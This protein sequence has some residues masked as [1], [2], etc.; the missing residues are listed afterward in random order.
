[1][2]FESIDWYE[3]D[4]WIE[5][6]FPRQITVKVT[7]AQVLQ[8][9]T[10]PSE[11][12]KENRKPKTRKSLTVVNIYT[13]K[14]NPAINLHPSSVKRGAAA[15]RIAQGPRTWSWSWVLWLSPVELSWATVREKQNKIE[16]MV[17]WKIC[18]NA[19]WIPFKNKC[20]KCQHT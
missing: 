10:L 2:S 12:T 14:S 17:K 18:G 3:L 7:L 5:I 16:K 19:L 4:N 15:A 9:P 8:F 11:M 20:T 13:S 1:M 6:Y